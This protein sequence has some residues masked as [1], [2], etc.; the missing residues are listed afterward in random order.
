MWEIQECLVGLRA[1]CLG[2]WLQIDFVGEDFPVLAQ[3]YSFHQGTCVNP[4]SHSLCPFFVGSSTWVQKVTCLS[5]AHCQE[6]AFFRIAGGLHPVSWG[7]CWN[8]L[9]AVLMVPEGG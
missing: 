7:C 6:G 9:N 3:G 2:I 8:Y 1:T 5:D 4:D